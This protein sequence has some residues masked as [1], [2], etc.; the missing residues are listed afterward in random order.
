MNLFRIKRIC[1][2]LSLLTHLACTCRLVSCLVRRPARS[3]SS[4]LRLQQLA[5]KMALELLTQEF[6]ISI[7]RLYVTYFGGDADAGLEPDLECKQI[8]IDLG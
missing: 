8:W 2:V 7:D 3:A 1:F 4:H 5:C 6:G